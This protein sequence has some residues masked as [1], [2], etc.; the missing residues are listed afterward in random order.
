DRKPF[1]NGVVMMHSMLQVVDRRARTIKLYNGHDGKLISSKSLEY[2]PRDVCLIS[3]DEVAVC[4]SNGTVIILSLKRFKFLQT[5]FDPFYSLVTW[6]SDKLVISGKKDAM[7]CWR[8][9][10]ITDGRLDSTHNICK[11]DWT[12]MA[13]KDNTVYISCR[14]DHPI[15]KGVHAFDLLNPNKQRF[16]YRHQELKRPGSIMADREYVY[17]CDGNTIHQLTDSG[18]LVTIHT[19]SSSLLSMFYDDQQG[20]LYTTSRKSNVITVYKMESLHQS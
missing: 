8:I 20:L 11:G 1:Y 4:L 7:L 16:L 14:T 19:V 9:V 15:N 18:Q 3:K 13:V 12:N 17:V 5:G 2:I 6:N 10:S